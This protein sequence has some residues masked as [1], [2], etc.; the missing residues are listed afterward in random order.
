ML[1]EDD[2][3]EVPQLVGEV[4]HPKIVVVIDCAPTLAANCKASA[5][6][7]YLMRRIVMIIFCRRWVVPLSLSSARVPT[8]SLVHWG[9]VQFYFN[10]RPEF[11]SS[12]PDQH[13]QGI[14]LPGF[15]LHRL[16]IFSRIESGIKSNSN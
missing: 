2:A 8:P 7:T 12:G 16:K 5:S 13:C 1:V 6:N 4:G 10:N 15:E 3:V 11:R 14:D 9:S